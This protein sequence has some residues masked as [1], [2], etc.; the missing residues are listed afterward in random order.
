METQQPASVT[1]DYSTMGKKFGLFRSF[2]LGVADVLSMLLLG[3]LA[4]AAV[5]VG[6][7]TATTIHPGMV[8]LGMVV[9]FILLF[10]MI[11]V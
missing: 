5:A 1:A 6:I 10:V 3:M 7:S 2:K 8:G 11:C 9:I 4:L